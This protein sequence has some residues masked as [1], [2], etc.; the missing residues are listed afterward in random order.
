[1]QDNPWVNAHVDAETDYQ[2]GNRSLARAL[3]LA[4]YALG[5]EPVEC[6]WCRGTTHWKATIGAMLC[7]TCN[8]LAHCNG[9]P[10]GRGP[11]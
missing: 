5:P 9:G 8:G 1:M 4:E 7:P 6:P 10:V 11:R 2:G 3:V